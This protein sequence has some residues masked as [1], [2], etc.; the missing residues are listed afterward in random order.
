MSTETTTTPHTDLTIRLL[1]TSDQA[2]L[3]RI[4]GRDGGDVPRAPLGAFVGREL[5][6]AVSLADPAARPVADPFVPTGAAVAVLQMRAEQLR[7]TRPAGDR[8]G[9]RLSRLRTARRRLTQPSSS[10]AIVSPA[11]AS[12]SQ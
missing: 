12:C 10:G 9:G 1:G 6:A 8:P 4:A 7:T 2:A 5:V 11:E 3:R